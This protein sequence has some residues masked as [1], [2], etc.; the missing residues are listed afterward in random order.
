MT[1]RR[2]DNGDATIGTPIR[3]RSLLVPLDGSRLAEAAVMPSIALAERLGGAVTLLHV[4]EHGAPATVHGEPHLMAA[5]EATAYLTRV[6]ARYAASGVPVATHVHAN[7]ERDVSAS[8]VAHAAEL[9]ADLVVL[10]SHGTGG[11]LGFLF[12][13]V[14]Q[15]VLRRG[16][17]PVLLIQVAAGRDAD[18][19]FTCRSMALLLNGTAE[20]EVALPA[21]LTL[22]DALEA[23]LHLIF[24]VP[25]VGT[26]GAD[27]AASATLMP[28]AAR[29]MLDLEQDEAREYLRRIARAVAPSG[30]TVTTTV[31]RGDPAEASVAEAN[32]IGAD[33]LILATHGRQG[34]SGIWAGS[35]G[36]KVLGRFDRPLLLVR[37]PE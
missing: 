9:D 27:R 8:I 22:A 6:A 25:T 26:L 13:R 4:L 12:G 24:A 11:I 34:L 7:P 37:V 15:Q 30:V 21:A 32:R 14:A 23:G 16:T 1:D 17:R 20:A 35:V 2:P 31:V 19:V 29:A 33:L 3:I 10:A 5:P 36:A 18:R 28:G